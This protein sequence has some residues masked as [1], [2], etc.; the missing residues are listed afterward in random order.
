MAKIK[1]LKCFMCGKEVVPKKGVYLCPDCGGNLE[2]TYNY[3]EIG[4]S[5][6]KDSLKNNCVFDIWRYLP[7]LPIKNLKNIPNVHIGGTPLYELKK[8]AKEFDIKKLYLKD[9]GRNPSASFK[10]RAGAI[11]LVNALEQKADVICGASTGN[12]ASSMACLT[13]TTDIKTI[14]FVPKTAPKA[15][16]AQLLVFGAK[17]IMVDGTYDDAFDLCIKASD[18][19][20]WY[21]R[22]TGYNPYTREGKKTCSLEIYE[23]LN[24]QVPDKLFVSVGDG[25]IISG[26]WKGWKDLYNL[27]WLKKLPQIIAVQAKFSNAVQKAFD[28]NS[29]IKSVSGKTV[30]DSISVGLPRDGEAAVQ[31][32]RESK[33]FAITVTDKQILDS[34]KEVARKCGVFGEPAGVTS[35][36][37]LKKAVA[38]KKVKKTDTVVFV[39][40]GNGL[41]D[42]D[43]AMKTVGKPFLI[44]PELSELDKLIKKI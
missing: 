33:G 28:S 9:D 1:C 2:V 37:G 7:L 44:K 42:I 19:Y 18:K 23:Q 26:I 3:D 4:K 8:V 38:E 40:T 36:A 39:V 16:V 30:A 21:N 5:Y 17:V 12:A 6:T 32:V 13:A 14:I 24:F 29:N 34:I 20:G 25:N 35:Y 41:K 43:S 11:A 31:A 10:D 27:G 15:K 22:N